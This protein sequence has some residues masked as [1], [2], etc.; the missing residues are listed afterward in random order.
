MRDQL[1][2]R[3]RVRHVLRL[4]STRH[5]DTPLRLERAGA[6]LLSRRAK[7]GMAEGK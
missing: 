6:R 5:L 4:G 3:F 7:R 2:M 1:S